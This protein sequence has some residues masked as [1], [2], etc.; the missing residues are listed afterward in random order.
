MKLYHGIQHFAVTSRRVGWKLP[1]PNQVEV[2]LTSNMAS[3]VITVSG[4][5]GKLMIARLREET[6]A[7]RHAVQTYLERVIAAPNNI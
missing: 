3:P 4:Q 2:Y 6:G 5:R 1:S 7:G